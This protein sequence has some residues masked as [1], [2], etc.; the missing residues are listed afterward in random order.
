MLQPYGSALWKYPA[1]A[2][3]SLVFSP[4]I[5]H[6]LIMRSL[7]TGFSFP[8]PWHQIPENIY[9]TFRLAYNVFFNPS[10]GAAV[11]Y[12]REHGINSGQFISPRP[13]IPFITQTLPEASIPLDVVPQ[14][15]TCA[16][17]I[18]LDSASAM[19]QD[20]VLVEWLQ[21]AP[22]VV[23][24]LGSLFKYNEERAR[25]MALAIRIVLDRTSVQF[26]WK[27]AR[28][29]DFSDDFALPLKDYLDQGRVRIMDWLTVDTLSLLETGYVVASIH[30][31]GSSSYNEAMAYV[32]ESLIRYLLQSL[33][34]VSRAGVIQV[35]IPIWEDHYNFA[36]MVEDLGLGVFATR[37][38]APEWTVNGLAD[39]F[40]KILD[41]SEASAKMRKEARRIGQIARRDPGRYVAAREIFKLA[42]SGYA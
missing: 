14:N 22:T 7:G 8:V 40:L 2:P 35:V 13:D 15:V 3:A 12:L 37:G 11:A 32:L 42:A 10:T 9:V 18:L 34:T 1:S 36:Q 30:H 19:E 29:S 16:G 23:I 31:G 24:N 28:G 4:C 25:I 41:S 33:L 39:P 17:A 38:T 21:K 20:S 6:I 5:G 26:L 27:M